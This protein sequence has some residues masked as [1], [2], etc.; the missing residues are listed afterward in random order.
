MTSHTLKD[1]G[2]VCHPRKT[3]EVKEEWRKSK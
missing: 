2:K 3:E 1:E